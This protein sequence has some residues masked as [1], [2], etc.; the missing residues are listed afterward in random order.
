MFLLLFSCINYFKGEEKRKS[1]RTLQPPSC[2]PRYV[3]LH[4]TSTTAY[5]LHL[6]TSLLV[7]LSPTRG[8]T[9]DLK[10][11]TVFL[12]LKGSKTCRFGI[13]IILNWRYWEEAEG[14]R[15][16]LCSLPICL[17]AGQIFG[18]VFSF[19]SLPGKTAVN[20]WRHFRFLSAQKWH[21]RNLTNLA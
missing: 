20:H 8:A 2:R 1:W 9:G 17:K 7:F 16:A 6:W 15:K 11:R 21:Q 3:F 18:Q 14:I 4:P 13:R 5:N 10:Q 19:P 12:V